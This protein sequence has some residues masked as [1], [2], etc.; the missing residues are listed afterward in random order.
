MS[1]PPPPPH[2]KST[3]WYIYASLNPAD[4]KPAHFAMVLQKSTEIAR[5]KCEDLEHE[6]VNKCLCL[7]HQAKDLP[8]AFYLVGTLKGQKSD[9]DRIVGA[10]REDPLELR[11]I[12]ANASPSYRCLFH[13]Q[14][15]L[16]DLRAYLKG[17]IDWDEKT[18]HMV[19]TNILECVVPILDKNFNLHICKVLVDLEEI[20]KQN[21]AQEAEK[22]L[23]NTLEHIF[24]TLDQIR[25]DLTGLEE[26]S[27]LVAAR[28]AERNRK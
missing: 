8:Y 23:T 26:I 25:K 22:N 1:N 2:N 4:A 7:E 5:F 15:K 10:K 14:A 11:G 24:L 19:L 3:I 27:K 9:F 18:L 17:V 20:R 21:A 12:P 6:G 28:E 16:K 13:F